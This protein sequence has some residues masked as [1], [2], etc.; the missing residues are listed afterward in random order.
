MWMIIPCRE[1]PPCERG[2]SHPSKKNRR[3]SYLKM[4]LTYQVPQSVID[5]VLVNM[6]ASSLIHPE[7]AFNSNAEEGLR[8]EV[9]YRDLD[10]LDR[11]AGEGFEEIIVDS[12]TEYLKH[13]GLIDN[14][15]NYDKQSF[16]KFREYIG[17]KFTQRSW[18]TITPV[19]ERMFYML[20]SVKKPKRMIEF[21]CYWGNTLAWFA[22]PCLGS[23]PHVVPHAIYGVDVDENAIRM[24][25]DNFSNIAKPSCLE[26]VCEDARQTLERLEGP[27]DFV[28]LEARVHGGGD[29][30]LTLIEQ[31]YDKVPRGA[32]IIAHDATWYRRKPTIQDY[33]SFVRDKNHFSE[34]VLF[35][36]DAYGVELTI[37]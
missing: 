14:V 27:F 35:D 1:A 31:V 3:E 2:A 29:M 5:A 32:W 11:I 24:A 7:A 15:A 20:T 28:Y 30:Y 21:G 17:K 19:M 16:L 18:T 10:F 33:L 6:K 8:K 22:G 34:S 23:N 13:K 4:A 26:I 9:T 37:K 36:I 12:A 25:K